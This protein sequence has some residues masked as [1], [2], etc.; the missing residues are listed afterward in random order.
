[1]FVGWSGGRGGETRRLYILFDFDLSTIHKLLQITIINSLIIQFY[2]AHCAKSSVPAKA[3][4]CETMK[5]R[6]SPRL[7]DELT[8]T[9]ALHP[10]SKNNTDAA[11]FSGSSMFTVESN[12]VTNPMYVRR[13]SWCS[14]YRINQYLCEL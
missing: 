7:V 11:C 6:V 13:G 5:R 10:R 9:F 2:S 1:V 14:K 12:P 8:A 3:S 4:T